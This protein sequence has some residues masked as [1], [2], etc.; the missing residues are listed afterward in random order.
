MLVHGGGGNVLIFSELA[1]NLGPDQ[2]IYAFQWSG[3]DGHRGEVTV[4][5]MADAYVGELRR[6][7]PDGPYRLGGHCIGGLIAIEMAYRLVER[8]PRSM[9]H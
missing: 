3:W 4:A 8:A 1:A 6:Y 2:P 7:A 9:V 5:E